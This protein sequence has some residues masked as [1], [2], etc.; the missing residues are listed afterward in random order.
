[1]TEGEG[2][3]RPRSRRRRLRYGEEIVMTVVRIVLV[4][5]VVA[6]VVFSGIYGYRSWQGKRIDDS[7][8]EVS[9][10]I[11]PESMGADK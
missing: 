2:R 8:L 1:M 4:L 7:S 5:L 6:A 10:E 9:R 11:V 3:Q